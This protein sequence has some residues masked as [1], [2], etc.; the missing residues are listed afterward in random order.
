MLG[1]ITG[2]E[3]DQRLAGSVTLAVLAIQAGAAIVRVHDV[4]ETLDAI[5]LL[6]AISPKVAE[7][8]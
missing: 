8:A 1:M 3:T 6:E 7:S 2:R 4:A 5:K